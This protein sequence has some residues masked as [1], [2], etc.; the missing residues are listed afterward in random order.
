MYILNK[1]VGYISSPLAVAI[2]VA[3]LSIALIVKGKKRIGAWSLGGV[4]A[5]ICIWSMPV[6]RLAIGVPLESE[7]LVDGRVPVVENFPQADAIVVLGGGMGRN[8]ELSPYGEMSS[9]ADRVW[10]AARLWKAGKAPI[11]ISTGFNPKDSTLGVLMDFGVE[12]K[13]VMFLEARNTEEEAKVI[14]KQMQGVGELA[15][16]GVGKI[17]ASVNQIKKSSTSKSK[18]LLVTSAWHMKRARLMFDK[19]A[20]ELDVVC[21]PADFEYSMIKY[22][23]WGI[24]D[25]LPDTMALLKNSIAVHEWIGLIGYKLFR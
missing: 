4:V 25:F 11:I 23:S 17:N 5:W 6:M 3:V 2:I 9:N 10:Q 7:F 16:E 15:N 22:R 8:V 1:I 12:E 14:W 21:A 18:V 24:N 13:S 19:Y 20:P